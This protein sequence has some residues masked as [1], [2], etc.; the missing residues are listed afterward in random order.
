MRLVTKVLLLSLALGLFSAVACASD[1]PVGF[2]SYDDI[3]GSPDLFEFDATS[4]TGANSSGDSTW[5]VTNT[6][7]FTNLSLTVYFVGGGQETFGPGFW[8]TDPGGL[9]YSGPQLPASELLSSAV[10]TGTFSPTLFDL[11]DG[12]HFNANPNFSA[13]IT[14]PT[15]TLQNGDFAIIYATP[16]PTTTPEPGTMVLVGTGALGL[17]RFRRGKLHLNVR[18][19]FGHRTAI[20]FFLCCLL[21]LPAASLAFA[22]S[23]V[24]LNLWTSPPSGYNDTGGKVSVAGSGFPSGS[25]LPGNIT[26]SVWPST[27]MSGTATTTPGLLYTH[28]VGT[29]GRVQFLIPASLNAGTY[30]VSIS[31]SVDGITSSNCSMM[32]VLKHATVS[33][34][35][36]GASMGVLIGPSPSTTVTAYVPDGSWSSGST[37]IQVAQIEPTAGLPAA[38]ST[39]NVT[40]S[41]SSNSVTGETICTANNTDIYRITGTT[42]NTT[43][44]S[45]ATSFL[46]F[47]GGSCETCGVAID[48]ANNLAYMQIGIAGSPSGGGIETF[49]LASGG[50]Q[51]AFPTF[52]E[53]SEDIQVDPGRHWVLSPDEG[54][55]YDL[56]STNVSPY[57]EYAM[58]VSTSGEFDSAAEDCTTGIALSTKSSP[59]A[60]SSPIQPR[61]Y[62]LAVHPEAGPHQDRACLS[63]ST[64]TWALAPVESL[65]PQVR[66]WLWSLANLGVM[67]SVSIRC[68]QPAAAAHPLLGTM[69]Q[70]T[71]L[72]RP[73]EIRSLWGVIRIRSLRIKVP[74]AHTTG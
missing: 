66:T 74:V 70:P 59:L 45:L 37:G 28:L 29:G 6:I 5:P 43:V 68:R 39:P 27:C 69:S 47:S 72:L 51:S 64:A 8:S 61:V 9:S 12:S 19:W 24:K 33:S 36:P 3:G 26:V 2:V 65:L 71:C 58:S 17:L 53:P 73:M 20:A 38:I 7:S 31:D 4:Q 41:C 14:D 30:P 54:N 34:C 62:L 55:V 56:I 16:A 52:Y 40:N 32:Q 60:S 48:E 25:I 49:N 23:V 50:T 15:G 11:Y 67:R 42:L 44:T 63:S 1:V 46:S 13:T 22:S 35:V 10:L 18:S 21:L 57:T